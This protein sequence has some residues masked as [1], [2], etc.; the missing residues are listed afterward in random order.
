MSMRSVS[1]GLS[2]EKRCYSFGGL[3]ESNRSEHPE[4]FS[5]A[6]K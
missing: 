6:R 4:E 3:Q 2:W 1:G 5:V